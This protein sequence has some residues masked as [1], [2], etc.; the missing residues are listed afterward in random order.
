[1]DDIKGLVSFSGADRIGTTALFQVQSKSIPF[2][3]H[4]HSMQF[5]S[6]QSTQFSEGQVKQIA[7]FHPSLG[8]RMDGDSAIVWPSGQPPVATR[9]IQFR[10]DTIA[11]SA[12]YA[13]TFLSLMGIAFALVC[14]SFNLTKRKLK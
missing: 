12:F 4:C 10:V 2:H 14:L 6:I 9:V 11:A 8:L 1:M 7:L 5:N 13:V 3:C